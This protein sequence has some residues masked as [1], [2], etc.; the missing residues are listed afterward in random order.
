MRKKLHLFKLNDCICLEVALAVSLLVEE[1]EEAIL[2][3]WCLRERERRTLP[4]PTGVLVTL[5][6]CTITEDGAVDNYKRSCSEILRWQGSCKFPIIAFKI[7]I[8]FLPFPGYKN[9][10]IW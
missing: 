5:R 2:F 1:E 7:V 10:Q 4:P 8:K 3:S 6:R 9:F